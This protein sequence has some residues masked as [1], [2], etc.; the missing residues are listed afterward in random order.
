ML[1]NRVAA[2]RGLVDALV[3]V[4][5]RDVQKW[6]AADA[7]SGDETGFGKPREGSRDCR[8][9]LAR[10]VLQRQQVGNDELVHVAANAV[11]VHVG[12]QADEQ[13]AVLPAQP[14]D[15]L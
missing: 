8:D 2:L 4:P 13:E 12:P 11:V 15:V 7:V 6:T 9:G 5:R 14:G 3:L 1:R 10:I